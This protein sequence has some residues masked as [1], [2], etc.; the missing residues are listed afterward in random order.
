MYEGAAVAY[1]LFSDVTPQAVAWLRMCG[2]AAVMIGV[3]RPWRS[4]WSRA[5][6]I[7]AVSFGVVTAAMNATF[8]MAT[9]RVHLGSTVAIE[10]VGPITVAAFAVRSSRAVTALV[11]AGGGVALLSVGLRSDSLGV[12]WALAAGVCWGGYVVLG[13][14]VSSQRGGVSGLAFALGVGAIVLAPFGLPGSGAALTD[15]RILTLCAAVGVLSTAIPYAIDQHV[16]RRITRHRFALLLAVLPV[17]ATLIGRLDLQQ[18][19]RPFELLGIALVVV[20]LVV[21]GP[22]EVSQ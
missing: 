10:F 2:A 14:R 3:A 16:L 12:A 7:S 8:Y 21:Q 18:S 4:P 15:A 19:P 1:D 5:Q 13:A 6:I 9:A 17:T 11:C 20:G 22:T